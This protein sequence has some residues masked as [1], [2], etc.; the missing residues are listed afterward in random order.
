MM[1]ALSCILLLS[2]VFSS[3][4]GREYVIH[5]AKII[6]SSWND[7]RNKD[8]LLYSLYIILFY[9]CTVHATGTTHIKHCAFSP[10]FYF[11][12][13]K[14]YTRYNKLNYFLLAMYYDFMLQQFHKSG[15]CKR[16]ARTNYSCYY[17]FLRGAIWN[18]KQISIS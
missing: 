10:E 17:L 16:V 13:T 15:L 4:E 7:S 9:T 2:T 12:C 11:K 14:M 18:N 8:D 6:R 3:V 5:V 1:A